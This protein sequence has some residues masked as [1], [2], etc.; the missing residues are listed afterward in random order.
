[1]KEKDKIKPRSKQEDKWEEEIYIMT[2]ESDK[3]C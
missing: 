3:E 2:D 1:M